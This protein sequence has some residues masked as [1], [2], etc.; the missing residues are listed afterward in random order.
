MPPNPGPSAVWFAG[1]VGIVGKYEGTRGSNLVKYFG[2]GQGG[3][4]THELP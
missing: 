1:F 3:S 4:K 2:A